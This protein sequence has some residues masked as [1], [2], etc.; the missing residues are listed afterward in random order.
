M[1]WEKEAPQLPGFLN[2]PSENLALTFSETTTLMASQK[3]YLLRCRF[4]ADIQH[5]TCI[6]DSLQKTLRL[7]DQTFCLAIS[8]LRVDFSRVYQL[9]KRRKLG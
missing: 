3:H 4:L 7:G 6:V 9:W 5:T 8:E 1:C 2:F